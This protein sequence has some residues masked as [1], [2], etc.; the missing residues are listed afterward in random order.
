[1]FSLKLMSFNVA[2]IVLQTETWCNWVKSIN[3]GPVIAYITIVI[4]WLWILPGTD[5]TSIARPSLVHGW[6]IPI[7]CFRSKVSINFEHI[8]VI[9]VENAH[10]SRNTIIFNTV[11][12]RKQF[13]RYI[14]LTAH[15]GTA[16]PFGLQLNSRC[17]CLLWW[18]VTVLMVLAV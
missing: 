14:I 6:T 4:S 12:S 3:S 15:L 18:I 9:H 8:F 17:H 13:K 10:Q 1:M 7:Y 16:I 2:W 11:Y 5:I